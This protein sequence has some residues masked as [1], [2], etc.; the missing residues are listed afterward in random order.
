MG[1]EGGKQVWGEEGRGEGE[2]ERYCSL[3][4]QSTD[5]LPLLQHLFGCGIKTKVLLSHGQLEGFVIA[6]ELTQLSLHLE[7]GEGVGYQV[8]NCMCALKLMYM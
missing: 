7:G 2:D 6:I 3:V 8:Y 1:T 5:L 4:E